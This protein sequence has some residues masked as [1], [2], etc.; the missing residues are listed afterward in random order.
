MSFFQ[1]IH[2]HMVPHIGIKPHLKFFWQKLLQSSRQILKVGL[3][4]LVLLSN[5]C[6]LQCQFLQCVLPSHQRVNSKAL[7]GFSL[8]CEPLSV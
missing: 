5:T 8:V 2:D 7:H 3:L 6:S 1:S 4:K